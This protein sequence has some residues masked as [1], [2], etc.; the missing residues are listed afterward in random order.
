MLVL[1]CVVGRG[2]DRVLGVYFL[3][4]KIEVEENIAGKKV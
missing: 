1:L 4:S 3:G 2:K